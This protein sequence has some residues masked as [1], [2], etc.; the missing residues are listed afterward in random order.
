MLKVEVY[1]PKEALK[2]IIDAVKD[3]CKVTDKYTHCMSWYPVHSM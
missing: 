3:Y 1:V 2:D